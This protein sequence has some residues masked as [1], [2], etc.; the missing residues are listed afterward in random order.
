MWVVVEAHERH[1]RGL[2]SAWRPLIGSEHCRGALAR[3]RPQVDL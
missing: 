3:R 1:L 2:L